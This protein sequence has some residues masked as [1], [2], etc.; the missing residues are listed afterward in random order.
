MQ[1]HFR[2]GSLAGNQFCVGKAQVTALFPGGCFDQ[3]FKHAFAWQCGLVSRAGQRISNA[4][5]SPSLLGKEQFQPG[6]FQQEII[7]VIEQIVDLQSFD[8]GCHAILAMQI[9]FEGQWLVG[10]QGAEIKPLQ[11]FKMLS[12]I[13]REREFD[14]STAGIFKADFLPLFYSGWQQGF[15]MDFGL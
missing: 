7:L 11:L 8:F 3:Q 4:R 5:K 10:R 14:G 15:E 6:I 9:H 13:V 1:F 2:F 12:G